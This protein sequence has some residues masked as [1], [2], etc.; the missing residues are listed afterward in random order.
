MSMGDDY[1]FSSIFYWAIR[2]L[3]GVLCEQY[4]DDVRIMND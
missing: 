4:N 3:D 1:I 2:C